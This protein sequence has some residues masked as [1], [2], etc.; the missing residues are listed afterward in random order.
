MNLFLD[1]SQ[2]RM[3]LDEPVDSTELLSTVPWMVKAAEKGHGGLQNAV[4]AAGRSGILE[5]KMWVGTLGMPTDSLVDSTRNDIADA[6]R[7][8]FES[9][10]VFVGD[11]EFEGHYTHFCHEVLWPALHYQMQESPRHSAYDHYSLAQY[12]RLNEAFSDAI[13]AH[14]KPGDS[15]WVHD[16]HL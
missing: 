15:I 4:H 11:T 3:D 7:N 6:L 8:R 13:I 12:V 9:L 2:D 16:Y 10:T 14:W 1:G 5:N